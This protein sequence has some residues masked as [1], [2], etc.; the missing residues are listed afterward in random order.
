MDGL[1]AVL[2][3]NDRLNPALLSFT[4]QE[5]EAAV[6]AATASDQSPWL[7]ATLDALFDTTKPNMRHQ[8][9]AFGRRPMR[10]R[11]RSKW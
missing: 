7:M 1:H 6:N 9:A 3:G 11:R 8:T 5:L 4:R 10:N 2:S